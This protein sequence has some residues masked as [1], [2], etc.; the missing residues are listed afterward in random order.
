M[1]VPVP[2]P[3]LTP[4]LTKWPK[5]GLFVRVHRLA[6]RSTQFHPGGSGVHGRFHFF[7]DA[8]GA[9]VPILYGAEAAEAAIAETVFR[10]VRRGGVLIRSRLAGLGIAEVRPHRDLRL[11]ELHGFGLRQLDLHPH[12][13]TSTD[14]TEYSATVAWAKALHAAAVEADG[15]V[16]MSHQFNAQRALMLF[17]DRVAESDLD[18]GLPRPLSLGEGLEVVERCAN[19]AGIVIV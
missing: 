4:R 9:V 7:T 17:G 19:D 12:E 6:F 2:P 13:L 5:D 10:D 14:P 16:W 15:L 18:G 8:A 3:A 11:I 1:A